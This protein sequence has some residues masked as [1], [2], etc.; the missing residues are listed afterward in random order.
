MPQYFKLTRLIDF[1]YYPLQHYLKKFLKPIFL[2]VVN[3]LFYW[4]S[5]LLKIAY[6][7]GLFVASVCDS[8]LIKK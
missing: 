2:A 1:L 5:E 8:K 6:I 3:P 7:I 4:C